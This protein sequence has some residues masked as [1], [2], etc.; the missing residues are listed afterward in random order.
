MLP[1]TMVR[2]ESETLLKVIP[3]PLFSQGF[4]EVRNANE[5]MN[6]SYYNHERQEI[7]SNFDASGSKG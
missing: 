4:E 1:M 6:V 2:I 7:T 5:E 3:S